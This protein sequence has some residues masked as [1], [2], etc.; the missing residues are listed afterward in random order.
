MIFK[1]I[2]GLQIARINVFYNGWLLE[3]LVSD[4]S[5]LLCFRGNQFLRHL[6]HLRRLEFER[7]FRKLL[8]SF[9]NL[10]NWLALELL[11]LDF[12]QIFENR[13]V[14]VDLLV[15]SQRPE[16]QLDLELVLF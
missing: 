8:E 13:T 10:R 9:L 5:G 12:G 4:G 14:F 7:N 2:V 11:F 6:R 3:Y 16:L 1:P 15:R